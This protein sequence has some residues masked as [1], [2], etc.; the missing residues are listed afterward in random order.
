[1]PSPNPLHTAL[2]LLTVSAITIA[3][4]AA[5]FLLFGGH[6]QLPPAVRR[7]GTL[8]PP[9]IMAILVV[10]CLRNVQ[11]AQPPHGVPELAALALVVNLHRWQGN[12]LLSIGAGTAFYMLLIRILPAA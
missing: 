11:P 3:L 10:Y 12:V 4:R 7:L 1:M 2:A 9:A 6:R 5:P 8:L